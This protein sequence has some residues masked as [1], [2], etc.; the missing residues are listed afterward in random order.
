MKL[1]HADRRQYGRRILFRFIDHRVNRT[2]FTYV[3]NTLGPNG[4]FGRLKPHVLTKANRFKIP[5]HG[6][7]RVVARHNCNR[8]SR[9]SRSDQKPVQKRFSVFSAIFLAKPFSTSTAGRKNCHT[10]FSTIRRTL[11]SHV[12]S[13]RAS[14]SVNGYDF[15]AHAAPNALC[16]RMYSHGF[17][18]PA[19]SKT[20]QP[21]DRV[22][23]GN[24]PV[25][26][27]FFFIYQNG[28]IM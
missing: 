18:G 16:I 3:Q 22:P 2:K 13:A 25:D 4:I 1:K 17:G 23:P 6:L 15:C 26:F 20:S 9:I 14:A 5:F 28:L 8:Q 19:G 10:E 11:F 24:V 7:R 27:F 21:F 12:V